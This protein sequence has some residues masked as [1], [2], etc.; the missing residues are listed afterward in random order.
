MAAVKT[1]QVQRF[2]TNRN[3]GGLWIV[4]KG[5]TILGHVERMS[6]DVFKTYY[7]MV[8]GICIGESGCKRTAVRRIANS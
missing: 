6:N 7:A 3:A 4:R 2:N 5:R 1:E 8:N